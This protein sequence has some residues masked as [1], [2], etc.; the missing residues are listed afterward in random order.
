MDALRKLNIRNEECIIRW[1]GT[2]NYFQETGELMSKELGK[3][4][5]ELWNKQI[6]WENNPDDKRLSELYKNA[7]WNHSM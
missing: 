5:P 7:S 3:N 1:A 4:Y 2:D 6:I